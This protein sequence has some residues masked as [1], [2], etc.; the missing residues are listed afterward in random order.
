MARGLVSVIFSRGCTHELNTI[1]R[2]F[3]SEINGSVEKNDVKGSRGYKSYN[4]SALQRGPQN[5][6]I[7]PLIA[8]IID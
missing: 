7:L 8:E 4:L 3:F 2:D 6:A 5:V 1:T